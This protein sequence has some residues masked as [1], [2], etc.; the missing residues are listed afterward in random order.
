MTTTTMTPKKRVA[1]LISGR[2]S[3][4]MALVEAANAPDFPAQIVSVIANRPD[5]SGITWAKA[6]GIAALVIDHKAYTT[7]EAFEAALHQALVDAKTDIVCLA[8]FMRILTGS[9]VEK[10]QG[11][12]V[13]IHPSLLPSFRGIY[14]HEQ[15]LAAGVKIAG[16]TVHF[17]VPDLD[18][19]PIIAQ[20]AVP[21]EDTD[22]AGTLAAR[23]LTVEHRIYPQSLRRLA[24]GALSIV[25][26]CVKTTAANPAESL[27]G[28][29]SPHLVWPD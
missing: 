11:R 20:A 22:T 26:G 25:H 5:A 27:P 21:V 23:I 1:I 29:T 7:R 16:C 8:G 3:N 24:S 10:W 6:R 9:F 19:G 13:N 14:T 18:A 17:V 2:G 15:A 28:N 4:M 12:M